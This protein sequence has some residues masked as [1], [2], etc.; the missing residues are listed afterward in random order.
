MDVIFE[1]CKWLQNRR[2][3][4]LK[5]EYINITYSMGESF[6]VYKIRSVHDGI[7]FEKICR[8]FLWWSFWVNHGK[9]ALLHHVKIKRHCSLVMTGVSDILH[10]QK[11]FS[12]DAMTGCIYSTKFTQGL[13]MFPST[14][15]NLLM[16]TGWTTRS[17]HVFGEFQPLVAWGGM[18]HPQFYL[19]TQT[20]L[21]RKCLVHEQGILPYPLLVNLSGLHISPFRKLSNGLWME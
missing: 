17:E 10:T 14:R 8:V 18:K 12:W 7:V 3:K 9:H 20:L 13:Y 11:H 5:N 1:L 6:W 4:D 16:S 19:Q 21:T 15:S 2:A